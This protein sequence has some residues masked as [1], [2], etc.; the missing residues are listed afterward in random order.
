MNLF[1]RRRPT[2]HNDSEVLSTAPKTLWNDCLG[3]NNDIAVNLWTVE[4]G[5]NKTVDNLIL[6][7]VLQRTSMQ[8]LQILA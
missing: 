7:H 2:I 1:K 8:T 3:Y 6:K 4:T 5:L